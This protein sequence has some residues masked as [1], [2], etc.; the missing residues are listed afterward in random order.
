[1]KRLNPSRRDLP[2]LFLLVL[3][4][5]I[6]SCGVPQKPQ[7]I[8]YVP[9]KQIPRTIAVMPTRLLPQ[10][11]GQEGFNIKPGS[12]DEAFVDELVRGVINNQLVGKGYQTIPLSRIDRKLSQSPKGKDWRNTSHEV[13]C[14]ILGANGL[15]FPEIL[16]AVMLKTVAYDEYSVE[17]RI[18]LVNRK[19]KNLGTWKESA[20][21]KKNRHSP[22]VLS[23]HWAT[24]AVAAMDEP[25][26]KHMRMVIYDWGWKISQFMPDSPHGK[27]LPE[28]ILVTTNVGRG[29]FGAKDRIE[30]EVNA[31]KKSSHVHLIW[32]I[33]KK[34]FPCIIPMP[35]FTKAPT[36]FGRGIRR[37]S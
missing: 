18:T 19:G 11:K 23:G 30:V 4:V 7:Q 15:I 25:A 34:A 28:I 24:V 26:K 6:V 31:E 9:E 35:A 20:S 14:R 36:W 16:S 3:P 10:K 17:A 22:P 27:D 5:L 29:V 2:L 12:R 37:T 21:K 33:L 8:S 32:G 13:I 1:M